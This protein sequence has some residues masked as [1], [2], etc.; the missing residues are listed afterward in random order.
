MGALG[1]W[2]L[3]V[4]SFGTRYPLLV[5]LVGLYLVSNQIGLMLGI[6]LKGIL[7]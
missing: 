1:G 6:E 2:I 5:E 7:F 4:V 3:V